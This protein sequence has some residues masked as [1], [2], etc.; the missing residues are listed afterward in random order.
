[1]S[2]EAVRVIGID[3]G[4]NWFHLVAM[5]NRGHPLFR[6]KLNRTQLAE[7]AVTAPACIVAMESCPGSQYWGRRFQSAGHTVRVIPAQF[8]KPST[9]WR[10][11]P[12]IVSGSASSSNVPLS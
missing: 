6:K 1:M 2:K 3:L 10:C 8:V 12:C 7:F 5:D 9:R 4:K 11:K